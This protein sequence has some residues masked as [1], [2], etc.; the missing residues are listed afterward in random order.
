MSCAVLATT[1]NTNERF[2]PGQILCPDARCIHSPSACLAKSV[3]APMIVLLGHTIDRAQEG[4]DDA[5]AEICA[6]LRASR[7]FMIALADIGTVVSIASALCIARV[8]GAPTIRFT[9]TMT[10]LASGK[11]AISVPDLDR[12]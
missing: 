7:A 1:N 2:Q 12:R 11:L 9:K 4:K 3:I 5:A 10:V 8:T 6:D